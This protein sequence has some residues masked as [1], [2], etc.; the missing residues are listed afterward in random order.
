MATAVLPTPVHDHLPAAAAADVPLAAAL[1]ARLTV[2]VPAYNEGASIGDTVRSLLSQTVRVAEVVV[3]DDCSTDDTAAIARALGVRVLTPPGNTGS[4]AG[5]QN[6]A[7]AHVDTAFTMAVDADTT[8]APDA[9][10]RLLGAF[11]DPKVAAACGLVLPR[12]VGTVWER[13]RYVEYLF[14][15]TFYKQV[16]DWYG[17]PLIASGCFSAYRTDVLKAHGGWPSRTLAED[18]D[19]TWS[20]YRSG[21][22]VRFVHD[23]VCYPVEPH[24]WTFLRRQLK[25]WSHGFVQNV[26]LHWR[27]VLEVPYLRSAVAVAVWDATVA[28]LVYFFVLPALALATRDPRWLLGYVLDLPALAVPVLAGAIP[29]GEAGRALASLPAFLVIRVVNAA[30]FLRAAWSEWVLG[31]EFRVF[32]KGH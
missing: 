12:H 19:L 16:Q 17:A 14:A 28:A 22:A 10:E 3:V 7:L 6:F 25:R 18:M 20:L 30:F 13:G 21:H 11:A 1:A 15:F 9:I 2:L 29:R 4:K 5:A 31:R 32:E 23:A 27:G 26:R 8:L 24:D